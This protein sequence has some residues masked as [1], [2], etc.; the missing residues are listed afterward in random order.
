[1]NANMVDYGQTCMCEH[2]ES[3]H[4]KS[5]SRY[6][7]TSRYQYFETSASKTY[8]FETSSDKVSRSHF[9]VQLSFS[10]VKQSSN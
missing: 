10:C 6:L 8:S 2:E 5:L 4:D 7:L 1:M 9:T 3:S